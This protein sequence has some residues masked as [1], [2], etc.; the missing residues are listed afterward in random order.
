[1]EKVMKNDV[2]QYYSIRL[3][4]SL[5]NDLKNFAEQNNLK[6]SE[7]IRKILTEYNDSKINKN[8]I[9][10]TLG[11]K[12]FKEYQKQPTEADKIDFLK[13]KME[14]EK[15][16]TKSASDILSSRENFFK[17]SIEI[18]ISQK[19]Q[20]ENDRKKREKERDKLL[21]GK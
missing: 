18:L 4:S 9:K 8:N 7:L 12:D 13:Q 6:V 14:I 15:L 5:L 1:M 3:K 16:N 17:K 11:N 10:D 21:N 2:K 19:R 20:I